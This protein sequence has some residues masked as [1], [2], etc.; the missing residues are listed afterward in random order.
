MKMMK[1][2]VINKQKQKIKNLKS[3]KY[4]MNNKRMVFKNKIVKWKTI[5]IK[6]I[7]L[8][9]NKLILNKTN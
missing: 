7:A 8:W 3:I 5:M 1:K 4:L 6:K 9:M 2:L